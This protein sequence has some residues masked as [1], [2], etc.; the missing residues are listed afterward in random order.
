MWRIAFEPFLSWSLMTSL[1]AFGLGVSVFLLFLRLRG[2]YLRIATIAAALLVLANPT[3][4][5]EKRENLSDVVAI[6]V[7]E[8]ESQSVGERA[9]TTQAAA[10]RIEE[11]IELLQSL[12]TRKIHV[13]RSGASAGRDGTHLFS[14]LENELQDVP[15]DRIGAIVVI[16][17]GQ[18]HDAPESY[19]AF[20]ID[21]PIHVLISGQKNEFDRRLTIRQAPA[22][23]IVGDPVE[24]TVR[25][26]ELGEPPSAL[27]NLAEI[28]IHVDGKVRETLHAPVGTDH[29][30]TV[31]LE[32]GGQNAIEVRTKVLPGELTH[33]NNHGVLEI[34]G[35]RDRLR[36]L[37]VS[38]EPHAGERTWRNL[39]KADPSVDLVHFTILRPP[40]K[41]DGTPIS[42]L[43][44]I[45]FPTRELF[46]EK[47]DDFDLIIFDRYRRR[48]VLPLIYLSNVAR[49]V[50]DGGALLTAVGPAF[51]TP[52][53]LYRTPL[54]GVLPA[55]PTGIVVETPFRTAVSALGARHPV[56]FDLPGANTQGPDARSPTWGRWFRLIDAERIAGQVLMTGPNDK[57]V[58]VL[59]RFGKGRVAQLLSDH[60]W[61]WARGYEGG[62]P[63]AEL[64]RRLAHWLMKEPQ[65]EEESLDAEIIG[66]Q[67]VAKRRTMSEEASAFTL[68]TPSGVER[69]IEPEREAPGLW[70]AA[71]DVD[72]IGV[73]RITDGEQTAIAAVGPLD[74]REYQEMRATTRHLTHLAKASGGAMIWLSDVAPAP[75]VR[76]VKIGRNR[77]G[78]NW[79]GVVRNEKYLVRSVSARSMI[80][81]PLALLLVLGL[82]VLAWRREGR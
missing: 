19:E 27:S 63:Q 20:G 74:P 17:D 9:E 1:G 16:S 58:L 60:G 76:R 12:E 48:G 10:A 36:V 5:D 42:E 46:S 22:F 2:A 68:T 50:E 64:L 52:L 62:G 29:D 13:G 26:D 67:L 70:S 3:L 18:V 35:V 71:V 82:L 32:H 39:L 59:D 78:R 14:A 51:A 11:Q 47:L 56:T 54:A 45:A 73:Y 8:S 69:E 53:S 33:H 4:L 43:S 6:V 61:L 40:E 24:L 34:S 25:V 30:I 15:R 41:Q 49:F 23:G 38:G 72:E 31:D 57:P 81:P 7:D 21:A 66:E 55:Q 77:A 80:A 28:E 37:L 79:I 65:L 44:L 75:N